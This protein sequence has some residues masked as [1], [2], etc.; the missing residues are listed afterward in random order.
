MQDPCPLSLPLSA[1]H[2]VPARN[3]TLSHSWSWPARSSPPQPA[4][5]LLL[6]L[7]SAETSTLHGGLPGAPRLHC[8][9][10][11]IKENLVPYG[12]S[13]LLS[14]PTNLISVKD[15]SVHLVLRPAS[16]KTPGA[17]CLYILLISGITGAYWQHSY[18]IAYSRSTHCS[19]F[20]SASAIKQSHI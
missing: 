7:L 14:T 19:P 11:M 3:L 12:L 8:S 18:P 4:C 2:S 16:R 10:P 9:M 20:F 13:L 15:T 1:A 5:W 6:L 17:P